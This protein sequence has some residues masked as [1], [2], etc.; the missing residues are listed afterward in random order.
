METYIVLYD[1]T[2]FSSKLESFVLVVLFFVV[3]SLH[4]KMGFSE[5][6]YLYI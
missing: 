1:D 3:R 4:V 5:G 2:K 6:P